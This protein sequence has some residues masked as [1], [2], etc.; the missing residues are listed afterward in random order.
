MKKGSE[1][2]D[3]KL[4][5]QK[6]NIIA[7]GP[8]TSWQIEREKVEAVIDFL[9]LGS[10]ITADGDCR[11]EIRRH[12]P[13]G[14]KAMTDL[15]RVKKQR[16]HFA[17]KG[18]YS[19]SYGLSSS[20]ILMWELYHKEG[21]ALKNWCFQTVVMEKTLESPLYCKEIKPAN[22]KRNQP[23]ILIGRTDAEAEAPI[24]WPPDV[25]SQLIGKDLML[26]KIECKRRRGWQRM[27][28]LD[29]ITDQ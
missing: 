3:F 19:Q 7:F 23:W 8:I 20:H 9:F 1:K 10:K 21:W 29:S 2:A 6:T 13:L 18:M 26:G 24:L 4:N 25:K 11:H 12:F 17:N 27:R 5:I 14:R 28:W 22:P 15:D 16:H